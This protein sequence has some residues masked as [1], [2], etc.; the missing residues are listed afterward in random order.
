MKFIITASKLAAVLKPV[1]AVVNAKSPMPVLQCVRLEAKSNSLSLA[2]TDLESQITLSIALDGVEEDGVAVVDADKLKRVVSVL[3]PTADILLETQQQDDQAFNLQRLTVKFGR[4]RYNFDCGSVDDYP[5]YT[6][7]TTDDS[8]EVSLK[9]TKTELLGLLAEVQYAMAKQDVRYYLNGVLFEVKD[10]VLTV[11][12]TDGHRLACAS[13]PTDAGDLEAIV[14]GATVKTLQS[15]PLPDQ[16]TITFTHN[17]MSLTSDKL[18]FTSKLIDGRYPDYRR[19]LPDDSS[20]SCATLDAKSFKDAITRLSAAAEDGVQGLKKPKPLQISLVAGQDLEV[21]LSVGESGQE[22][23][24]A[25]SY[26]GGDMDLGFN[27]DYV[28]DALS[29]VD[30]EKIMVWVRDAQSSLRIQYKPEQISVL[31][32]LRI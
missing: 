1:C 4:S 10:G 15:L 22:I 29:V 3:P 32:P 21:T 7:E 23:L 18:S 25:E 30:G 31:M 9:F 5:E 12:A 26:D 28:S 24:M 2:G 11:V 14:A 20:M 6:T 17:Q 19:V 13:M 16:L 8:R 27:I